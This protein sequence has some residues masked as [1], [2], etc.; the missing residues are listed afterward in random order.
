MIMY[1]YIATVLEVAHQ[2]EW[3]RWWNAQSS[4]KELFF[5]GRK[6]AGTRP[7]PA[8]VRNFLSSRQRR[9]SPSEWD[10]EVGSAA[11]VGASPPKVIAGTPGGGVDFPYVSKI[12]E[13]IC[14]KKICHLSFSKK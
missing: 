13:Y 12:L 7:S 5:P 11:Q 2:A 6:A 14:V 8:Q 9:G 4:V 1:S 10:C 3:N